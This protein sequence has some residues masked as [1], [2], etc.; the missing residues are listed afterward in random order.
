MEISNLHMTFKEENLE[1]S[2]PNKNIK[3]IGGGF[4]HPTLPK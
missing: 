2:A 1:L 3:D 4:G